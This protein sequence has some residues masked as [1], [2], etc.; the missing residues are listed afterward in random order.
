MRELSIFIDESGDVGSCSDYYLVG[1]VFH[2][3]S[4]DISTSISRYRQALSDAG[5]IERTFHFTPVVRGHEQYDQIDLSMRKSYFMRFQVFVEKTPFRYMVLRYRKREFSSEYALAERIERELVSFI[6]EQVEFFF[7][8]DCV[9]IY[10]DNGQQTVKR[11]V[12]RAVHT[13]LSSNAA[14]YR[15]A[16]PKDYFMS[17]VADYVCGIEL[18]AL[19]YDRHMDSP[20]DHRF[21]GD[22]RCFTKNYLKKI[23]RKQL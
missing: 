16:M 23:R 11:A 17:R 14:I 22:K 8:Y 4:V 5:L 20:T 12:H 19:R 2:D 1:F 18:A 9:K 21:F 6:R 3:Q 7:G 15:N 10:Y 13:C